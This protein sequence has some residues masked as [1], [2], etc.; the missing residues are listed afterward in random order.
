MLELSFRLFDFMFSRL[1]FLF[2]VSKCTIF[3][4]IRCVVSA[5][6]EF[7]RFGSAIL[8]VLLAIFC[9]LFFQAF[10]EFVEYFSHRAQPSPFAPLASPPHVALLAAAEDSPVL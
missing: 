8:I 6:A 1:C 4:I 3:T 9:G 5:I 2:K 7:K 10:E